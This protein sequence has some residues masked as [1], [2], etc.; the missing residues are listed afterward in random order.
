MKKT[1][2]LI[3]AL[4]MALSLC[5]CGQQAAPSGETV[6]GNQSEQ[7]AP[8]QSEAEQ[9]AQSETEQP[10]KTEA[11]QRLEAGKL[12][13]GTYENSSLGLGCGLDEQWTLASQ[14][15]LAGMVG[16]T[17]E[18]FQSENFQK[19][20]ESLDMYYD[21]YAQRNDGLATINIMVQNLGLVYGTVMDEKTYADSSTRG[22]EEQLEDAG[23]SNISYE[24]N[25]VELAGQT[26]EGLHISAQ[27]QGMDYYTQQAIIKVGNYMV[28][29]TL[30]SFLEDKAADLAQHFYPVD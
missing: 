26:R 16:Q 17:A 18:M 10:A 24:R 19:Q 23:F 15:E 6:I 12:S 20:L 7:P 28:V 14:E 5:A 29:V 11:E 13:G 4:S 27:I 22:L 25:T 8:A 30:A 2:A 21:F 9:P 3:L 1:L